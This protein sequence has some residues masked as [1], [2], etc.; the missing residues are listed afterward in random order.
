MKDCSKSG[1]VIVNENFM[2]FAEFRG[3]FSEFHRTKTLRLSAVLSMRP[4]SFNSI[5]SIQLMISMPTLHLRAP[6][7]NSHLKVDFTIYRDMEM[8]KLLRI[9]AILEK[10]T[11]IS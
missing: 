4:C 8:Q 3:N 1:K 5:L 9:S 6:L 2:N 11:F 10:M 7:R